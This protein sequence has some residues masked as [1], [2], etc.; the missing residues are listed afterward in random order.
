M[1]TLACLPGCGRLLRHLPDLRDGDGILR[2]E[3]A[4]QGGDCLPDAQP[5]PL[6]GGLVHDH[7]ADVTLRAVQKSGSP[8]RKPSYGVLQMSNTLRQVA[9]GLASARRA[10]RGPV[11]VVAAVRRPV[12]G[13]VPSQL[14]HVAGHAGR[15][16]AVL[17]A[18]G[19][20]LVKPLAN[21]CNL[22]LPCAALLVRMLLELLSERPEA[23]LL[24]LQLGAELASILH[25]M[26]HTPRHSMKQVLR[27][28]LH[29]CESAPW[30]QGQRLARNERRRKPSCPAAAW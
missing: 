19:L 20:Q 1:E 17:P 29:A 11:Q 28:R 18:Q 21:L 5:L 2:V 4:G 9:G 27:R 26:L 8:F 10:R 22:L 23:G 6:D 13:Q 30:R 16:P 25:H 3:S 12:D 15:G 7:L 24:G 14:V